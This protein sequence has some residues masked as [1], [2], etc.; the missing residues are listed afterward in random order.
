MGGCGGMEEIFR[1][2]EVKEVGC[3]DIDVPLHN[4][5]FEGNG[6]NNV[7]RRAVSQALTV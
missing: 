4:E 1:N 3:K 6:G 2:Q 7:A 5:I